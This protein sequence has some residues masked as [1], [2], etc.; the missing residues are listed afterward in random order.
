MF[1]S[2]PS[3]APAG[4]IGTLRAGRLLVEGC[5]RPLAEHALGLAA[6]RPGEVALGVCGDA[7]VVGRA[8]GTGVGPTGAVLL[9]DVDR[10]A[11]AAEAGLARQAAASTRILAALS[12]PGHLPWRDGSVDVAVGLPTSLLVDDVAALLRDVLRC[13][14]PDTGRLVLVLWDGPSGAPHEAA[15]AEAL[16]EALGIRSA[17]IARLLRGDAAVAALRALGA[18]VEVRRPR[19]VVRFDGIEHAWAALVVER[20]VAL[21]IASAPAGAVERARQLL[22]ERLAHWAAADGT[23]RIPVTLLAT[24]VRPGRQ[25]CRGATPS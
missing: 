22:A 18:D 7:G 12:A 17:F 5:L 20:P 19:D 13:L 15:L 14:C 1:S 9:G 16:E 23:L 10:A 11:L 4:A 8:L 3:L 2:T 24:V 21:E 6:V 25:A